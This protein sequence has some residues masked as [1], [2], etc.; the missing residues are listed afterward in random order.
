MSSSSLTPS[1]FSHVIPNVPRIALVDKLSSHT[2]GYVRNIKYRSVGTQRSAIASEYLIASDFGISSPTTIERYVIRAIA[3]MT[4]SVSAD[5]DMSPICDRMSP[6]YPP[7]ICP[8][9]APDTMPIR[10][11]PT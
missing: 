1:C 8:P 11:M 2:N 7:N 5:V 4:P 10:V 3:T 6:I 9:Y